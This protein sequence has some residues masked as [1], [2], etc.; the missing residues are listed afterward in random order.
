MAPDTGAQILKK[1]PEL[2]ASEV[3]QNSTLAAE[4]LRDVW[5]Q[6]RRVLVILGAGVSAGAGIQGMGDIFS[7]LSKRMGALSTEWAAKAGKA[8]SS[9]P[10]VARL[11]REGNRLRELHEWLEA[12]AARSAPRSTAAKAL[13]MLQRAGE[14]LNEGDL[15][16]TIHQ[17]WLRFSK[18][19]I[20]KMTAAKK[21]TKFHE[22]IAR[23]AITGKADLISVNFDGLTHTALQC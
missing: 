13:G 18:D 21:A 9:P 6:G 8:H 23:W 17:E 14:H 11:G 15:F 16:R 10:E 7:A 22:T 1:T 2:R 20:D 3:K 12:L 19:F 5:N 4:L